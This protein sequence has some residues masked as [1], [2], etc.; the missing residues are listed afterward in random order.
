MN[1]KI[2]ISRKPVEYEKAIKYLEK[3]VLSIIENKDDDFF[4]F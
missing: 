2:K 3:R 4:G 1:I